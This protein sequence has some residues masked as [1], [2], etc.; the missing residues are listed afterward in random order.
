MRRP[1]LLRPAS[2]AA[3]APAR[4]R[5]AGLLSPVP[6]APAI[7]AWLALAVL[8]AACRDDGGRSP[9]EPPSPIP[10]AALPLERATAHFRLRYS[11]PTAPLV[12][13]YAASL[14][15]SRPR[16][17]GDLGVTALGPIEGHLHPDQAAFT[18]AT[19]QRATGAVDGPD[20]FHIVAVPYAPANAQHELAH[21][22]TLHL[23]PRAGQGPVWLWESVA[24]F[25]ARQLVH[26]ATVPYLAAG[27]FPTLAALD[28]EGRYS[29]YDV[30]FTIAEC[31]VDEWGLAGLRRLIV[32]GGDTRGALGV[33][34]EE[35][36]SRWRRC[37]ES[38]YL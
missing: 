26:P 3:G 34:V 32:A 19:G 25:E 12:E 8:A 36:E 6:P 17:A 29:I 20:R 5:R 2:A 18:A 37:V 28:R 14:E 31:I 13:A 27:D 38:R 33:S 30:G 4:P 10:P 35:L 9:A 22:V 15:E 16:I 11:A 24:L 7:A 1:S 23:D 21:N